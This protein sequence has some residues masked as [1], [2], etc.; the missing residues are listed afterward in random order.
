MEFKHWNV[1]SFLNSDTK[2]CLS[3]GSTCLETD[4][5]F[6]FLC[7]LG[8]LLLFL[9]YLVGIPFPTW[10]TKT[11]QKR[12]GRAKRRR[13]GGT[14]KDD[15]WYQREVEETRKLISILRS[16]LGRH[17]DTIHFRQLLCPDPSCEVCNS[18]T[19]EINRL[20]FL[21]ALEDSTPLASTAAVTSSS[22]TLSPDF[23]AVPPGELIPASL[24]EPSPPPASSFSPNPVIPVA[25]FFPPS[26]PGDS[27]PPKPFPPSDPKFQMDHFPAQSPAC[28]PP[29]PPHHAHS[30]DR[31]VQTE[32]VSLKS[33]FSPEPTLSQDVTPLL[34]LSQRR[35]YPTT[36]EEG[37]SQQTPIQ[38]FWGLQTPHSE[39][40]F[41]AADASDNISNASP[42]QESPVVP[43]PLPPSLPE[44]PPQLLPQTQP[45]PIPQVQPQAQLQSPLPIWASGPLPDI[46]ICGVCFHRPQ[47]KSESLTSTEM[48]HVEWDVLQK[49][50][51]RVWGLPTVVQR[52]QEDYCPSAPNPCLSHKATK[53]QVVISVP[54]G[55]F[56]LNEE[57]RRKLESH[58]RKRL[59]QHRWG[60]PRRIYESLA[61][62][63]GP[64]TLPQLPESQCH[65]GHSGISNKSPIRWSMSKSV[66]VEVPEI[67]LEDSD[68]AKY[69]D[70]LMKDQGHNPENDMGY[71]SEK[72]LRSPS[73]QN[74]MVSVETMGQRQL[75][76]ALKTVHNSWHTMQQ[77]SLLS[78]K[79]QTEI[80]QGSLPPSEVED[81]SL[82]T[83]QELPLVEPRA[84]Q[85]LEDHIKR[86]NKRV[87]WGLPPRVLESIQHFKSR[88]STHSLDGSLKSVHGDKAG[89]ANSA[90]IRDHPLPATST[91]GK[92]EQSILR[93]SPCNI[94]HQLAEDVLKTKNGSQTP[95]SVKRDTLGNRWAPRLPTRQGAIRREAKDKS[96][97][98]GARRGRQ[99]GRRVKNP[100]PVVVPTESREI[101]RTKEFHTGHSQP[102]IL[103]TNKPVSSQI[104]LEDRAHS[105]AQAPYTGLAPASDH[106]TYKASLTHAQ[107]VSPGDTRASQVLHV[108]P[109]D[110]GITME[111]QQESWV[112]KQFLRKCQNKNPPPAAKTMRCPGSKAQEHGGGDAGLGTSQPRM[113]RFPTEDVPS[114]KSFPTQDAVWKVKLGSQPSQTL[115]QKGQLPPESLSQKA[116]P[117]SIFSKKMKD[118]L[119]WLTP[120]I[121]CK[122]HE[123]SQEKHSPLSVESRGLLNSRAAFTGT[124]E[125]QKIMTAVGKIQEERMGCRRAIG[126]TCPQQPIPSPTKLGKTQHKAQVQAQAQPVPGYPFNYRVPACKET[127]TRSCQQE[128]DR[129]LRKKD[130]QPQKV[131]AFKDQLPHQKYPLSMPLRE[132]AP[133]PK[134]T[135]GHQAAQWTP[136]T[137]TTPAGTVNRDGSLLF[138]QKAVYRELPV[139]GYWGAFPTP[140]IMPCEE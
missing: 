31:S 19:A 24:P 128:A 129:Q 72:E 61:L 88:E 12:Q 63:S 13:K 65:G 78:E 7:G 117:P 110:T 140:K 125:A 71:D 120:G 30:V 36:L 111:Q 91:V 103:T 89:T 114:K 81:Y 54:P 136:A 25:G 83:F 58:L 98:T 124:P 70:D 79:S 20:L 10:K 84:A 66:Y 64:S 87:T 11:T 80:K 45:L 106:L 35:P 130:R 28:P 22:F 14:L 99:Q 29:V 15:R 27:L 68:L 113:N 34:E 4:P 38:F 69:E 132:P 9:C 42:E 50:Q 82:N 94:N 115:S 104:I 6:A 127:D 112:P 95:T 134:A 39:S 137:L 57:L 76:N 47:N 16:P 67:L 118:F 107:G 2:P 55:Q 133:N 73:V 52:S 131:V 60:L 51:K 105:Q 109:E 37:H 40:F 90:P 85:K 108:H 77:T 46:K 49:V 119:Q 93:P 74:S 41:P 21:Q 122:R 96:A 97:N 135:C 102:R 101:F 123:N 100:E 116:Q 8:L 59:I 1:L 17:H 53:A 5:N 126:S 32:T 86:L 75:E 44:N 43:H 139:R 138:Q 18:T 3:F 48:Q 92:E 26:P 121:Q 23:S 56:P 33:I 62:M